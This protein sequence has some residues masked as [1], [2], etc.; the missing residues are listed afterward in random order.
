MEDL[1]DLDDELLGGVEELVSLVELLLDGGA[2][3]LALK[4]ELNL[5]G[6]LLGNL[7]DF[8]AELADDL[9]ERVVLDSM[10]N[11]R[12]NGERTSSGEMLCRCS[13]TSLCVTTTSRRRMV[14][15][16]LVLL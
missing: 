10:S 4:N 14:M 3:E 13:R 7:R 11:D 16:G 2:G 12:S 5:V 9:T 6:V 1:E 15:M 8:G